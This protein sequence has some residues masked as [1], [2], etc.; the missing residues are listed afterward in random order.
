MEHEKEI[1]NYALEKLK[2]INSVKIIG[3]PN[4]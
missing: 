1:K 3:N 4:N 2:K